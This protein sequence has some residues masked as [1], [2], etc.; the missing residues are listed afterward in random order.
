MQ[1]NKTSAPARKIREEWRKRG[2]EGGRV[3]SGEG[4]VERGEGEG[5]I[6][7]GRGER[8]EMRGES[9]DWRVDIYFVN[10]IK[11]ES[12]GMIGESSWTL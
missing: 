7:D 9:G 6:V 2:R 5:E 11:T 1:K 10:V 12:E 4:S 8:G 3:E